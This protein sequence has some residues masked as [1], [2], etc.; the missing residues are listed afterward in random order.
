MEITAGTVYVFPDD[1]V[2]FSFSPLDSHLQ[3]KGDLLLFSLSLEKK[4]PVPAGTVY[5]IQC[6]LCV[7]MKSVTY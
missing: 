5:V 7:Y 2:S 4:G 3:G 1:R 6:I